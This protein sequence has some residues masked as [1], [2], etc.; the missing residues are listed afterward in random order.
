MIRIKLAAG[1][2]L[3]HLMTKAQYDEQLA[4]EGH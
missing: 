1:A 4:S 3:D 2:G